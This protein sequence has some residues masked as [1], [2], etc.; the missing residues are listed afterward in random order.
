MFEKIYEKAKPLKLEESVVTKPFSVLEMTGDTIARYLKEG[1]SEK[2]MQKFF[3]DHYS[4]VLSNIFEHGNMEIKSLLNDYIGNFSLAIQGIDQINAIDKRYINALIYDFLANKEMDS[5]TKAKL[6]SYYMNLSKTVNRETISRLSMYAPVDLAALLAM[7]RYSTDDTNR[8]TKRVNTVLIQQD[9]NFL[10]E[11]KIVDIYLCLYDRIT[12]L[13][14]GIM[15]DYRNPKQMGSAANENWSMVDLAILDILE[16]MPSEE[17]AKVMKSFIDTMR[18]GYLK[19][20]KFS[21]TSINTV[22]YPRTVSV[23]ESVLKTLPYNLAL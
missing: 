8:A 18:L 22:D 19:Q 13:F 14:V 5:E 15:N 12:P 10:T 7:A 9:P 16:N 21:M 17:I 3:K 20:P 11:Q 1:H 6:K 4:K 23:Y 2:D